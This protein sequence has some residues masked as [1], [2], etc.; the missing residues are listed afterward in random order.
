M[1]PLLFTMVFFQATLFHH[2]GD[3]PLWHD[4]APAIHA[5]RK[6]WW[7]AFLHAQNWIN[8]SETV[9]YF[10]N[11]LLS[12]LSW[13]LCT[14]KKITYNF[15]LP[16]CVFLTRSFFNTEMTLKFSF[17]LFSNLFFVQNKY[18]NVKNTVQFSVETD[19]TL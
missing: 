17:S 1:F 18:V 16:S 5:C 15:L 3:G 2:M 13:L 8:P 19:H 6:Y 11:K 14:N 12:I 10:G 9:I 7:S 4:L